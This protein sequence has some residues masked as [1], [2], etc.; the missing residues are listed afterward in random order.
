MSLIS[1]LSSFLKRGGWEE[2]QPLVLRGWE[3]LWLPEGDTLTQERQNSAP[4]GGLQVRTLRNRARLLVHLSGRGV[5]LAGWLASSGGPQ[6]E[7]TAS[8][9]HTRIVVSARPAAGTSAVPCPLSFPRRPSVG[10]TSPPSAAAEA[11]PA[12]EP[13]SRLALGWSPLCLGPPH[14]SPALLSPVA[15]RSL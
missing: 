2:A 4:R 3:S 13:S 7:G 8:P 14:P 12:G 10:W 5:I 15:G 11:C 1:I 9:T 6:G